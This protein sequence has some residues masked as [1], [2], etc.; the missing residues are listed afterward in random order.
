[1][2]VLFSVS[3]FGFLRNF[4]AALHALA[5]RGHQVHLLAERRET[6]GGMRTID[7]L[8]SRHEN[9]TYGFLPRDKDRTWYAL[10][11]F[12]RLC[13]DYWRY[14]APGYRDAHRLRARAAAQAPAFASALGRWPVL[15][16]GFGLR[17]VAAVFDA[18]ERSVP[19]GRGF[20]A[21]LRHEQPDVVLRT[22]LLYLGSQQMDHVR[23][24]R[25]LGIPSVLGVGSWD[26]LTTKGL[27]HEV[28]DRVVVW[29]EMQ[30]HEAS[31]LHRVP[32]DRVDVTGAQAY[33]H[34]FRTRPSR[35]REEFC[36][37]LGLSP[38]R[39][40]FL[41]LCS[42]P[43][44]T[45]REV[46]LVKAWIDAL[47]SSEHP[48][49]RDVALLIRPHPQNAD[50][51]RDVSLDETDGVAIWPRAGANPVDSDSRSVYFDSMFYSSAVVGVNT[52]A[53]IE[54]SILGKPVYTILTDEFAGTQD[55]TLHFQHLK[56]VNGGL[57]HV[58]HNLSEHAEQLAHSLD[59]TGEVA[60]RSR[61]FVEAF[62]RP[63][64][65]D[66]P[67]GEEFANA[68]E[69]AAELSVLPTQADFAR[70]VIRT[71]I[72]PVAA[73]AHAASR[74]RKAT[75]KARAAADTG[76]EP[77]SHDD[78]SR[79]YDSN[80]VRLLL[81][82]SSPE[83]LRYY[84]STIRLL[85]E[86]G[87]HVT[88]AVNQIKERKQARLDGL[89]EAGERVRVIG[90]APTRHD[91]WTR[92]AKAIRGTQDFVRYL[93]PRYAD[94][95]VLRAR[96][97]RKVLPGLLYGLDRIDRLSLATLTL[98]QRLL[99]AFERAIPND[100][101]ITRFVADQ[102]P[103][104]VLVS[105][106]VDAASP[107]VD[108]IKSA[109]ALGIRTAACIASWDNLT[110]KGVLRV[111]PDLVVV[112]NEIQ[113]SEA[114][115]FHAI[116]AEKVAVTGAQLFDR[117]FE[118][119]PSRTRE[120]FCAS[121]GLASSNR[122]VLFVGSSPFIAGGGR[123]VPFVKSWLQALR[124]HPS[125]ELRD[126]GVLVRPHPYNC[127][128]WEAAD[129]TEYGDV[130]IWP[131]R[132]YN[133]VDE[134][135]RTTFFDSLYYSTAVVGI[136][137]S[138]MVESAILGRPVLSV[139]TEAFAGTQAGT[140]HFHHLRPENGGFLRMA[141]SLSMHADQLV[142]TLRNEEKTRDQTTRFVRSFIRPQGLDRPATPIVVETLEGL[143]R[144]GAAVPE[145]ASLSS[146]ALRTL[147]FPLAVVLTAWPLRRPLR[148]AIGKGK[149][150][151]VKQIDRWS[152]VLYKHLQRRWRA[153]RRAVGYG[154]KSARRAVRFVTRSIR[155]GGRVAVRWLVL[156]PIRG[157]MAL[158][159][160]FQKHDDLGSPGH[161][162][163]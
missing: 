15:G 42:S 14:L 95:P 73:L 29:N 65:L 128:D 119:G 145:R 52:S 22:P 136:N 12:V 129:L 21:A 156:K 101:T 48:Q 3:H 110:N 116:P 150:R 1:M 99:A 152:R 38:E 131:R 88:I 155:L 138:A 71:A 100:R 126:V 62:V 60:L 34:W 154:R 77:A 19:P 98:V 83:F 92:L 64:G 123:E 90:V 16:H 8:V 137:T 80:G 125:A 142:D 5:A 133:A 82:M 56:N 91:L 159:S 79:D 118:K 2:K 54:S 132:R 161:P 40:L 94:A 148:R 61:R 158:L 103:D 30:R 58:A 104:A 24:A 57:L 112:W 149:Y 134:A 113:K 151:T 130:A 35:S 31:E 162:D 49:L 87:H 28:P 86:R 81:V 114:I 115:D 97:K 36:A 140:L 23:S 102:R 17:V 85:A 55:G 72:Y 27:I 53:L 37:E 143:A 50:Q 146:L 135:T 89:D 69:A 84:D 93:H 47:R 41:Y 63:C 9:I 6:L 25:A 117:W 107:Q 144:R 70:R 163:S 127:D 67:A 4:E 13:L 46:G 111:E 157:V 139:V 39:P 124:C 108:F 74:R 66:R 122:F 76:R 26:H 43:F 51:W 45:P 109:K 106:L 160:L 141:D 7:N 75:R 105:P 33:D 153:V 147:L 120:Q 78:T 32:S 18:V 11:T 59:D 68:L 96:I 10:A 44:I 121:V 20:E